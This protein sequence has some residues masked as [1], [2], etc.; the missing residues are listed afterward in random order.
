MGWRDAAGAVTCAECLPEPMGGERVVLVNLPERNEWRNYA[1][2]RREHER[3][4]VRLGQPA[5]DEPPRRVDALTADEI[6]RLN[7]A[8]AEAAADDAADDEPPECR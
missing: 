2:E 4:R 6:D 5:D 7:D 1:D 3:R 8:L